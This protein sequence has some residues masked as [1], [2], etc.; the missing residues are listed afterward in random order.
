[1]MKEVEYETF[2]AMIGLIAGLTRAPFDFI[3][4]MTGEVLWE[5]GEAAEASHHHPIKRAQKESERKIRL[6]GWKSE[7]DAIR[8][9]LAEVDDEINREACCTAYEKAKKEFLDDIG[10]D[11]L[12]DHQ[13]I[14][15]RFGNSRGNEE[16]IA[17]D[18]A[19]GF[20][21]HGYPIETWCK[22]MNM[23]REQMWSGLTDDVHARLLGH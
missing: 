3:D 11:L 1:M 18:I 6:E 21:Y 23:G 12:A 19:H 4:G 9:R 15:S 22:A 16:D 10:P 7:I 8:G 17:H 13:H 5:N 2:T 14:D 20:F